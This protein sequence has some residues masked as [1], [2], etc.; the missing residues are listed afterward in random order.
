MSDQKRVFSVEFFPPKDEAG[1]ERLAKARK[2]LGTLKPEFYSVTFG[3]GGSTRDRT[4]ETVRDIIDKDGIPAAP[5]VSC[6]SST[7]GE[8]YDLLATYRDIGVKRIVAL[9]GDLPSGTKN[10]GGDFRYASELVEF[11]RAEFGDQFKIEVAAYPEFH[12]Q[13]PN[14]EKDLENFKTKVDAGAD[15]AITQYFYNVDA[16]EAFMERVEKMGITIPII[17]GIMPITN[18][19]QIV[20][21]SEMC[22]A[23]IPRYI[24][25]RMEAYGDDKESIR[26][27]GIEIATRLTDDVLEKGAPGIHFYSMNQAGPT[28]TIWKN[29]DLDNRR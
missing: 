19:T 14:A 20:R 13:A 25:K 12:P 7:R 28:E 15:A 9:R 11:V 3:A 23:E 16:Y 21:F 29:L 4:L 10:S 18:Y 1:A 6:I 8:L 26:K 24:R 5:H 27:F 2:R 22:G 17:V